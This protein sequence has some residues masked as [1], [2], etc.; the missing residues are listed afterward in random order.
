MAR[1]RYRRI[2]GLY[3]RVLEPM[4]APLR[5]IG[6]SMWPPQPGMSVL[7]VGCGTGTHLEQYLTEGCSAHGID[8][9]PAMLDRAQARLGDQADLRLGDA[10]DLP[11]EDG[12]FD[13]VIAATLLH[14]LDPATREATLAEMA[15]VVGVDGRVLVIDFRKGRLRV[16]KGWL[17]RAFSVLMELIAGPTHVREYRRFMKA[18]G[19]PG[20]LPESLIIDREKVVAGGNMALHLLRSAN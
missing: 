20:T 19:V 17:M 6:M 8:N 12:T 10:G 5:G 13:L 4:N 3:D 11:W 18:G 7:D 1:D 14:E 2:A 16:P 9:S 15:R